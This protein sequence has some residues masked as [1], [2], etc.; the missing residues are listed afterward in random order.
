MVAKLSVRS[1]STSVTPPDNND[2]SLPHSVFPSLTPRQFIQKWKLASNLKERSASQSHFNDICTIIAEPTPTDVDHEGTWYTFEKGASKVGAGKGWADV[3]RKGCF[4]WEYKGKHKDLGAALAQLQ[5]Y[6]IALDNPPLLVVSDMETIIIHTNFNNSIHEEHRITLDDLATPDAIQK[7]KDLFRA[8]QEFD[9]RITTASVTTQAAEAFA[10]IAQHLRGQKFDGRRVAHFMTKLIFCMFAEDIKILPGKV[11]THLVE[12]VEHRPEKFAGRLKTL[13]GAM[14][15][16]GDYGSADIPWFNGGLFDNDDTL[17]LDRHGVQLVLQAA[18]LDWSQIEPSIF[19]TLFER[20]LDP[21]KRSQIGAHYTDPESIRRIINPVLKEPLEAEWNDAK[22]AI[23]LLIAAV[24]KAA[25][26]PM[27]KK[28]LKEAEAI[29]EDFLER[30]CSFRVLDAGCGSGNFLYLALIEL[31]NLEHRVRLE[32]ETFGFHRSFYKIGPQNVT[33]IEINDYAAEL[34]RITIWIG[35]IQW[36]IRN[37][38]GV[39]RN[40]VL[41]RLEQ[42][43]NR[44]AL[45]NIDGT[46]A[47]WPEADCI[48]GNPPF[49]GNKKMLS[50]LG[51]NYV[52]QLRA[53][54]KGQVPGD[55]ELVTYWFEKS[56][57]AIETGKARRAGLVA[58]NSIRGGANRKV[59]ERICSSGRIISAWSDE[60]WVIE[61][62]AVRVSLICFEGKTCQTSNSQVVAESAPGYGASAKLNGLAVAG[63]YSDLTAREEGKVSLDLT[64]AKVL[65][66]NQGRCFMGT[67]KV[68]AFDISAELA[69]QWLSLPSNPNGQ[70]NA[71][72]VRPWANGMDITRRSSDT[73]IVDFG[74]DT[75]EAQAA[76]YEAPFEYVRD[77]VK[78]DRENNNREV[79]RRFWWRHAE[80]RPAMRQ[81]LAPLSRFIVTPRVAKHRVFTWLDT[82]VLPDSRLYAICRD[83]DTTFGILHSRFHE[84]WSL[85]TCSWHGAGN[86]P[87]YNAA[88]CFET[89]PFPVGITPNIPSVHYAENPRAQRIAAASKEL[90]ELREAWLHP[91]ELV[92]RVPEVV[93]GFPERIVPA[94]ERAAVELKKRTLTNL[95]NKKPQWL[96]QVHRKLD[97]AVAAAYGWDTDLSDEELLQQL[98]GLNQRRAKAAVVYP[99]KTTGRKDSPKK[100][101]Q[102]SFMLEYNGNGKKKRE[103]DTTAASMADTIHPRKRRV[104]QMAEADI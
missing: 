1:S 72:V 16:G 34:A 57:A 35:E 29:Y 48:I 83:D 84:I 56:R 10:S 71:K 14:K 82:A 89:F 27:R 61:G 94:N 38:F 2:R 69:R 24:A 96:V 85:R 21:S 104:N 28:L 63:I 66:E 8:P 20:G 99:K 6:A 88:S 58:T 103:A 13:F 19:G 95:Y 42:I 53:T 50:E 49:L 64:T 12:S 79:Y 87:T 78:P 74:C 60:P 5:R 23:D 51:E 98:L 9:P 39:P 86:D 44:D 31:K 55:A 46:E 62:A 3:W 97:E 17:P 26:L 59:L 75:S 52:N 11:F 33:G 4:A 32:G 90:V 92:T 100:P 102:Q 47:E 81:A 40:P 91:P 36:M 45:L 101:R 80:S 77:H 41:K 73:W 65:S 25:K 37:G 67:T 15:S 70:V 68:G 93:S 43:E 30:L 18:R 54:Y 22:R 76:F 7:L